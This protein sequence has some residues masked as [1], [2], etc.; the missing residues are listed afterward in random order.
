MCFEFLWTF[1]WTNQQFHQKF[2]KI[3][4]LPRISLE[5]LQNSLKIS[6][7]LFQKLVKLLKYPQMSSK[8]PQ[9]YINSP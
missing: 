3:W 9:N 2:F 1:F 5:S 7:T 8:M 6:I 4:K